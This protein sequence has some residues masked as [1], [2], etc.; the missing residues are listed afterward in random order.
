MRLRHFL[1]T[2]VEVA[3]RTDSWS[4]FQR[5]RAQEWIA[6][7]PVFVLTLGTDRVICLFDINLMYFDIIDLDWSDVASME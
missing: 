2:T 1:K 5:E 4:L 3:E 7:S 6:L